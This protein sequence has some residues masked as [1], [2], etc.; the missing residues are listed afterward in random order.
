MVDAKGHSETNGSLSQLSLERLRSV[1]PV[2]GVYHGIL[3]QM[4][5][6]EKPR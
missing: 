4:V 1:P 5:C 2:M 3:T 6:P